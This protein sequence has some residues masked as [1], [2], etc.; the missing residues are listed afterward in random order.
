MLAILLCLGPST[1]LGLPSVSNPSYL[2]KA[3]DMGLLTV[4]RVGGLAGFGGPGAR[5]KSQGQFQFSTLSDA[6]QLSV[7][8]LFKTPHTKAAPSAMRDGF[9]YRISR[10][11]ANGAETIEVP[12][13][14]LPGALIAC[15]KDE[16]I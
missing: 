16:L 5:I 9:S 6:D 8:K 3:Q 14:S 11:T 2:P 13:E 15:V 12:G 1:K 10:K 4:E 7:E